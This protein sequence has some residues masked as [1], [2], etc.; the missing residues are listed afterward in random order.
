[1]KAYSSAGTI[2]GA[3]GSE[4]VVG[5]GRTGVLNEGGGGFCAAA[6]L[7]VELQP[8]EMIVDPITRA[9]RAT[10]PA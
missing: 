6:A 9:N 10:R 8:E 1:M 7:P 2:C 3:L 5:S 4:V